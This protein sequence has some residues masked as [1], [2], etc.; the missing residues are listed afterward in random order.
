MEHERGTEMGYQ[1]FDYYTQPMISYVNYSVILTIAALVAI[2]LGI[3]LFC[4]FLKPS[5]EGKYTGFKGKLYNM[6]AFNRFYA[7]NII[8]FVYI[9]AACVVTVIGIILIVL[10]SFIA[11]IIMIV[12]T[13]IVLRVSVELILMFIILCRKTASMDRRLS[14][15]ENFYSENYD[16]EWECEFSETCE[17]DMQPECE[18]EEQG[19]S[20]CESY[21]VCCPAGEEKTEEATDCQ[22]LNSEECEEQ[23]CRESGDDCKPQ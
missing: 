16:D 2:V 13:N 23:D 12:I 6:L 8:K 4:T 1:Y 15:I 11:G 10:G 18:F 22:K 9:I 3:V 5:H 21:S 7:E 19:C 14:K 17:E 20:A